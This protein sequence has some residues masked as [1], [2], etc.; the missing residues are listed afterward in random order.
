M[1][2]STIEKS[3]TIYRG[4]DEVL[5]FS[6][7]GP[8]TG[9]VT[10]QV[11]AAFGGQ[12][13]L[14]SS[15][16]DGEHGADHAAGKL[17]FPI[18]AGQSASL[19]ADSMLVYD[20]KIVDAGVTRSPFFGIFRVN[21]SITQTET[22]AGMSA[23]DIL[24]FLSD[25]ADSSKG[26]GLIGVLQS[27]WS[28]VGFT[29]PFRLQGLLQWLYSKIT[30]RIDPQTGGKLVKTVGTAGAIGESAVSESSGV[31]DAAGYLEGGN[32]FLGE[33]TTDELPEGSSNRYYTSA[34]ENAKANVDLT[35]VLNTDFYDKAVA[36]G[37]VGGG[38]S[39]FNSRT[40]A[41]TPQAGDYSASQVSATETGDLSGT[42]VQAQLEDLDSR[43]GSNLWGPYPGRTTMFLRG[44][45]QAPSSSFPWQP[46]SSSQLFT[47]TTAAAMVTA[48]RGIVH[49]YKGNSSFAIT[50]AYHGSGFGDGVQRINWSDLDDSFNGMAA[51]LIETARFR[52]YSFAGKNQLGYG[53]GN[54]IVSCT[55][56]AGTDILTTTQAHNLTTGLKAVI[57]HFM[58]TWPETNAPMGDVLFV[59]VLS[60]TT[61]TM[62]PTKADAEANTNI[63]DFTAATVFSIDVFTPNA[64]AYPLTLTVPETIGHLA[65]GTYE[66]TAIFNSTYRMMTIKAANNTEGGAVSGN[67]SFYEH[68]V[69]GNDTAAVWHAIEDA[70]LMSMRSDGSLANGLERLDEMQGHWH[71]VSIYS[72]GGSKPRWLTSTVDTDANDGTDQDSA[73]A[74]NMHSDGTNGTP[75]TG[76][77]TRPRS[78]IVEPYVYVGANTLS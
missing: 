9:L 73:L 42:T 2:S 17:A 35:N 26:A 41:V 30:P 25:S 23:N 57:I 22:P 36:A 8:V 6:G 33:H 38:V 52:S 34:R 66:I 39:S 75:R 4:D 15:S 31:L 67:V 55:A 64:G 63:I 76:P 7:V 24:S 14:Q 11:A 53:G 48:L 54:N 12:T 27:F 58:D 5:L 51:A 29:G 70:A 62:H 32:P 56:N 78:V 45:K 3:V 28:G 60:S 16:V 47:S 77:R 71:N 1:S 46:Y 59:R 13:L 69:A 10:L 18:T 44:P 21:G 50:W 43:V 20:V 72:T 74:G 37:A 68:R 49:E 65:A 61:F 40:G 19:P